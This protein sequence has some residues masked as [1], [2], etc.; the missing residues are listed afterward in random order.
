MLSFLLVSSYLLC[1]ILKVILELR[2]FCPVWQV[3]IPSFFYIGVTEFVGC[4][5]TYCFRLLLG[6]FL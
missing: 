5:C 3:Y 1:V 6:D 2:I 4:Y